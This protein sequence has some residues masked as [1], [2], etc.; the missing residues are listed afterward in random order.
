MDFLNLF[1]QKKL[2]LIVKRVFNDMQQIYD[3]LVIGGGPGIIKIQHSILTQYS[4]INLIGDE[5]WSNSDFLSL[6]YLSLSSPFFEILAEV[7]CEG[8]L[9]LY[10]LHVS[11]CAAAS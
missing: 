8:N 1:K 6:A 9:S 3:I 10:I 11:S 5:F 2:F 4:M 7:L